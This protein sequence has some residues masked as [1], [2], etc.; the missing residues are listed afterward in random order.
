MLISCRSPRRSDACQC[1]DGGGWP[2]SRCS[3]TSSRSTSSTK[4]PQIGR[5][6]K[7]HARAVGDHD[8]VGAPGCPLRAALSCH[9]KEPCLSMREARPTTRQGQG[10]PRQSRRH[11]DGVSAGSDADLSRPATITRLNRRRGKAHAARR[12]QLGRRRKRP[13]CAMRCIGAQ[14]QGILQARVFFRCYNPGKA[15]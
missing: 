4:A 3:S 2:G 6:S 13:R 7:A 1:L 14:P 9:R 15:S 10:S 5:S 11:D 8:A 12:I